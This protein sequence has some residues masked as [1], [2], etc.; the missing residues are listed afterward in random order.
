MRYSLISK[1]QGA[2]FGKIIGKQL[3]SKNQVIEHFLKSNLIL[4]DIINNGESL[5]PIWQKYF[6]EAQS[7]TISDITLNLLPW[8]LFNHDNWY[9][10][11]YLIVQI[12]QQY[13]LKSEDREL[14]EVWS[15]KVVLALRG[16][17]DIHAPIL[18]FTNSR[19]LEHNVNLE[20][21][22]LLEIALS[23]GQT[24]KQL[25]ERLLTK[26]SDYSRLELL[27]SLYL[28]WSIPEDFS[29]MIRRSI[30]LCVAKNEKVVAQKF[31]N[32]VGL[33]GTLA[34]A[35]NSLAGISPYWLNLTQ[36]HQYVRD[37]LTKIQEFF[38]FWS[39]A[40]HYD[41]YPPISSVIAIPN[42]LQPRPNLKLIS[43]E[44]YRLN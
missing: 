7:F 38:N 39:G 4:Q 10:L 22:Q 37:S 18:Q 2:Y 27:F 11:Q 31:C 30:S 5:L 9:Q 36:N 17:L 8:I 25:L 15:Y 29:L 28:F 44:E 26:S 43:Q 1:F 40:Y 16:K 14:I 41:A 33:T 20:Q 23:Q 21:L 35:Y 19:Q 42:S 6:P 32:T 3:S 12:S 34:G 13:H 24:S